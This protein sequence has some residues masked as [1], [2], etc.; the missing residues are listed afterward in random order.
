MKTEIMTSGPVGTCFQIYEDFMTYKS[1][2]YEHVS[3]KLVGSHCVKI[4]GWGNENG[5]D[6]WTAANSFGTD[7]GEEGFF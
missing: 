1:G 5:V 2:I 3:G 4:L 6:Y 7:W